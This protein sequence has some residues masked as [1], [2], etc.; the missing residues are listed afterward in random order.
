[1]PRNYWL[2]KHLWKG[3]RIKVLRSIYKGESGVVLDYYPRTGIVKVL[4]DRGIPTCLWAVN[5]KV[6][7]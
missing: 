5:V 3:K 2:G 1:M 7:E 4:L 6:N